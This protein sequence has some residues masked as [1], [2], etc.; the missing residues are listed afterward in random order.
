MS[1]NQNDN[2]RKGIIRNQSKSARYIFNAVVIVLLAVLFFIGTRP[3]HI[4]VSDSLIKISGM[5]G[6]ELRITDIRQLELRDSIP[7]VKARV[8]GMDL[9]GFANRGIYELEEL[10]RCRLFSFSAAGPFIL[11]Q[12]GREWIIIN[13][14]NSAET[15]SLYNKLKQAVDH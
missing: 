3:P 8:N 2:Q 12:A 11:M 6:V 9:F 15:E 7:Q 4:D 5:Y 13:Y 10:G 1:I 14:R